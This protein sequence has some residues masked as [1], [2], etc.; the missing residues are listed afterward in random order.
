MY[1]WKQLL[2]PLIVTYN[3]YSLSIVPFITFS[4]YLFNIY[5]YFTRK[6]SSHVFVCC[7]YWVY[8]FLR[9]F[10]WILEL[11]RQCGIFL[12]FIVTLY[13]TRMKSTVHWLIRYSSLSFC[14]VLLC[15]FTFWVLCCDVRY[16]FRIKTMFGSSLPPVVCRRAHVLCTLFVLVWFVFTSRSL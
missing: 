3:C 5:I 9:L 2:V 13:W 11:F 16:N 6:V 1:V 4:N 15:V 12:H 8:N 10:Y 14:V 7:G